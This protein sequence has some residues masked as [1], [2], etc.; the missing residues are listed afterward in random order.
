MGMENPPMLAVPVVVEEED[1]LE[2]HGDLVDR[3]LVVAL[4]LALAILAGIISDL[5]MPEQMQM[6]MEVAP[7]TVR[8][9]G[10][11]VAKAVGLVTATPTLNFHT[12]SI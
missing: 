6:A 5:I 4:D 7:G 9:V 8:T 3:G 2:V 1:K 10:V 12:M 11:V